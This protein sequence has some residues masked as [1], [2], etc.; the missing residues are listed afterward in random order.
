MDEEIV[1]HSGDAVHHG[2]T[3]EDRPDIA[4]DLLERVDRFVTEDVEVA[5]RLAH[6]SIFDVRVAAPLFRQTIA[7]LLLLFYP[8]HPLDAVQYKLCAVST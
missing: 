4:R 1:K 6:L 7:D 3:R 8:S 5:C 2:G